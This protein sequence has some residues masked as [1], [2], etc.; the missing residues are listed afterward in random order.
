MKY[1]RERVEARLH[2]EAAPRELSENCLETLEERDQA[3][4]LYSF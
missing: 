1:S 4:I 3:G 2:Q